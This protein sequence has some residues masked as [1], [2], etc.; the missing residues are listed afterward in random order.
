M[1]I[2]ITKINDKFLINK[3]K[4]LPNSR[5]YKKIGF[6][7]AHTDL[8]KKLI[9]KNNFFFLTSAN[10][11]WK[12]EI[13]FDKEILKQLWHEIK[14][15]NIQVLDTKINSKKSYSDIFEFKN[16]KIIYYRK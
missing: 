1:L 8:Q 4:Q 2:D 13:L 7:I 16:W 12:W 3:I 6:R 5:Q 11:S 15:Y 14:K 9:Q 10:K